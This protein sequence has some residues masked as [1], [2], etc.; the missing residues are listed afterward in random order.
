MDQAIR[1][2]SGK[3]GITVNQCDSLGRI[4]I[5]QDVP[6][7]AEV[8]NIAGR[9]AIGDEP[10][11]QLFNE[12][13]PDFFINCLET[14]VIGTICPNDVPAAQ[15]LPVVCCYN[16]QGF[17]DL[18]GNDHGMFAHANATGNFWH[19]AS[20]ASGFGSGPYPNAVPT[21]T[22]Y[23]LEP[24]DPD[25]P[26]CSLQEGTP[27]TLPGGRTANFQSTQTPQG[28]TCGSSDERSYRLKL[29]SISPVLD[30]PSNNNNATTYFGES[31]GV[32]FLNSAA[33]WVIDD[34]WC[35]QGAKFFAP[36]F[37]FDNPLRLGVWNLPAPNGAFETI[38]I[39]FSTLLPGWSGNG[40]ATHS[41]RWM[42][43]TNNWLY[44]MARGTFGGGST[45]QRLYR[46]VNDSGLAVNTFW[47]LT[48]DP[49]FAAPFA[50]HVFNDSLIFLVQRGATAWSIGFFQTAT[51]TTTVIGTVPFQCTQAGNAVGPSGQH[52][53][54]YSKNYFYLS[55]SGFGLGITN[56][57]KIGPLVCPNDPT[58]PWE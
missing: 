10:R 22:W 28:G 16:S 53:F 48:G 32:S 46:L 19:T 58:I 51:G 55:Y 31:S 15:L 20:L 11:F 13:L 4:S 21:R 47:T 6:F 1:L 41:L 35:K 33:N 45:V 43:A 29:N 23:L 36:L 14:G 52:G 56:V 3:M 50:F 27:L 42:Q 9:V 2:K 44:I 5:K 30:L 17:G 49:N 24:V 39:L 34:V 8:L 38:N 37:A 7:P 40:E 57:L 18:T 12:D 26:S 25:G 54:Y